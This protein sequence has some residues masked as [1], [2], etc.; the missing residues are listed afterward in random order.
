MI[1]R[2]L[3]V[4]ALMCSPALADT[5]SNLLTSQWSGVVSGANGGTSGGP[6]PAYN[7]GNNTIIFSWGQYTTAQTI[8][9]NTALQGSGVRVGGYN[10]SWDIHNNDSNT[11]TIIGNVTLSNSA[12]ATLHSY[13][14]DYSNIRTTGLA[15]NFQRFSGTQT[16]P[17]S[18]ANIDLSNI[19][20]SWTGRDDR[21]WA[22]YYGPRVR[23]QSL[24]L[25]YTVDQCAV[26]PQSSPS[27]PGYKTYY[28]LSDDGY[29]VVPL[30]FT[31]PFYGQRFNTSYFFSNGVIG[32]LN[33]SN[34][35]CCAG[36][37]M[38]SRPGPEWNFAIYALQTDLVASDPN[39][40]FYT[41][42]DASYMRYTWENISEYGTSNNN[43]FNAEIRPSGY[44]GITHSSI[45]AQSPVTIGIAGDIA[46]GQY[47][48]VY[49]G[50][51]YAYTLP[52]APVTF[53]GTET[54][55]QCATNPLYSTS[56]P[57]Y[58]EAMCTTN[59]LYSTSC[60]GYQQAHLQLQ[61]STNSLY[62]VECPGYAAAYLAYQCSINPLYS[63]TCAGYEQAYFNQQCGQ[64]ALYSS[65]CP[66]YA[67]AYHDQ[68]CNLNPLYAST[69]VGYA[70]AYHDQQCSLNP[71]YAATCAGY[72]Q[73]YF[74]QQCS[75]SG[76]YDQ[77]CPNYG[78][79]YAKKA[80]LSQQAATPL[81]PTVTASAAPSSLVTIDGTVAAPAPSSTGN[82]TVDKVIAAPTPSAG[83]AAPA[84]PVQL[85]QP[86]PAPAA[87]STTT[88]EKKTDAAPAQPTATSSD[89][90]Q[91]S[92]SRQQ[93]AER[94]QAAARAEA[95]EK[96]KNLAS[97]MGKASDMEAQKQIQNVVLQAMGYTPGFDNYSKSYVPDVVGYKPFTIY[98]GQANVDNKR[99][100]QGLYGPSDKTHNELVSSQYNEGK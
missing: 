48:Q 60:S 78:E 95:V 39:A 62:S 70:S 5:T 6:G 29:A 1:R 25:N 37:D 38:N 17:E 22:G 94:R 69:C 71:L 28:N 43:T 47:S 32:F 14:Y 82:S 89:K 100:G 87:V 99:L 9:I 24:T 41:Q 13:T 58:T 81:N 16:F 36:V 67:E 65:Q 8:A 72:A 19:T 85:V 45:T 96:G 49:S 86:A 80:L 75:I 79:A 46:L 73:A 34:S 33:P 26:N 40:K 55:N 50:S 52:G 3:I 51:G 84:A 12:G 98:G 23:N 27:C 4:L 92:T 68:Q 53:T 20:L 10:Y 18:Y 74:T 97:E 77:K 30:P 56:C 35:F 2:L 91:P 93:L 66:G 59:P 11:G 31:F 21:G 76:L 88:V 64:S 44:V 90:P 61:C 83:A 42:G 54:T 7:Y 63:T 15:E 57:G